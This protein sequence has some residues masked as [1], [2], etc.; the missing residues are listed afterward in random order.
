MRKQKKLLSL[1]LAGLLA[2]NA[3]GCSAVTDS[4]TKDSDTSA[5][6]SEKKDDGEKK[7]KAKEKPEAKDDFYDHVNF[8]SLKELEIPY[9]DS[10]A[11]AFSSDEAEEQTKAII[12][13]LGESTEKF[14]PGSNEQLVHDAYQQFLSY[15]EDSHVEKIIMGNCDRIL[16]TKDM[17]ELLELWGELV[18][19][20]GA[21]PLL[22]FEVKRDYVDGT[23]Y[24]LYLDQFD[25]FLG[26]SMKEIKEETKNVS[27][28]NDIA[29]DMLRVMG[30]DYE[31][32]DEKGRQ[33]AYLGINIAD[34]TNVD[35]KLNFELILNIER[36]SFS[37]LKKIMSNVDGSVVE[38]FYGDAED[39]TDGVYI[40]DVEQLKRINELITDEN[41]EKWQTYLLSS[42]LDGMG[43]YVRETN[44]ILADYNPVSKR[45]EDEQAFG[46]VRGILGKRISEL[47]AQEYYTP[48][49]DK[50]V[51]ELFD[52]IIA[53]YDDLMTKAEWLSPEAR[54][55][56]KVKLHNINLI[57]TPVMH[58]VDKK[59][60]ELIGDTKYDTVLNFRSDSRSNDIKKLPTKV[61][62][63]VP[64]ML[65][66]DFNA[67]Y[68]P[69]NAIN[70]TV[71]I[72]QKP[73]FDVNGDHAENLGGLG[74]VVG[75]EIGH[76][77]DSD[78]IK[79]NAEGKYDPKWLPEADMKVLTERADALVDY[80]SN[81]TI[82]EVYH[83]DGKQTS[84]ENYADIGGMECVT[85]ILDDKAELDRMFRRYAETWSTLMVDSEG[86]EL[87]L[88]DE[89][90]PSKARVNAVLSSNKKFNEV[91][92][93]KEGDG[94][95]VAPEERVSRW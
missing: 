22:K 31:T 58:E 62:K 88:T 94:M 39:L 54:E 77:F 10:E 34:A 80:Y 46:Y 2:L 68:L 21:M 1:L 87:L 65:S 75:H 43:E 85:N 3:V 95:Y 89:H 76:A 13:R 66:L 26:C 30:D 74:T 70:I 63:N 71:A 15:K 41:F 38:M 90:S 20:Y 18:R 29:R 6:S 82:M 57:T 61:D 60:A 55:L 91:Y 11:S 9:G 14:A 56:L 32:A 44:S 83:I 33:M 67:Q 5:K 36:T 73:M 37:D 53:S 93:L 8:D 86:I 84:G 35:L 25:G 27:E 78:L 81:Y 48:E 4:E 72:M 12:K 24:S 45:A 64:D 42:Y 69:C 59:D 51:H 92:G 19:D 16:A 50:G 52:E 23:R 17:N 28:A 47:Y 7:K 40:F 79:F 49:L